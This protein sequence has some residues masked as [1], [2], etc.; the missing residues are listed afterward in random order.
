METRSGG[1]ANIAVAD[2]LQLH[3]AAVPLS[4]TAV[5]GDGGGGQQQQRLMAR[6]EDSVDSTSA[7]GSTA[8]KPEALSCC[9]FIIMSA[10][11]FA[12]LLVLFG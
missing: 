4:L 10:T 11:C 7:L 8:T 6:L 9:F 2:E 1:G 3:D 12:Q 5:G